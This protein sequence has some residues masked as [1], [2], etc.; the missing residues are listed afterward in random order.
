MEQRKKKKHIAPENY[1]E[2]EASAELK[3]EYYHGETFAMTGSSF[4]RN[5]TAA[6]VS[7]F[8]HMALRESG[9]CALLE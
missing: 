6:N 7:C 8:L 9:C 1:P 2:A 5:L 3:S 4:N